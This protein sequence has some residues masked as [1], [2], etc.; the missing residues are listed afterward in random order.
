[1]TRH[2]LDQSERHGSPHEPRNSRDRPEP[3][4]PD[5]F[6]PA[7]PPLQLT[8]ALDRW[9]KRWLRRR[10]FRRLLALEDWQLK[11]LG[12]ARG[13]LIWAARQPLKEDAFDVLRSRRQKE[14]EPTANQS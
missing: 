14:R 1:M 5:F 2:S 8:E 9:L 10:R 11:V 12:V 3:A 6:M 4:M 7:M 13:D